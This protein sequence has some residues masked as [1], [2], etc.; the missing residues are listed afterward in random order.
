MSALWLLKD[1]E[2]EKAG[3]LISRSFHAAN[4]LCRLGIAVRVSEV[5]GPPIIPEVAAPIL[6][7]AEPAGEILTPEPVAEEEHPKRRKRRKHE[8]EETAE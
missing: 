3:A 2:G 1:H 5:S 4:E 8:D 6:P 7:T